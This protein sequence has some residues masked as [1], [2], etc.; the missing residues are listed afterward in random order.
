MQLLKAADRS[1]KG[2]FFCFR[3]EMSKGKPVTINVDFA[4]PLPLSGKVQF[5]F[6]GCIR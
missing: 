1:Q 3:N 6:V 4:T 2:N 5:D